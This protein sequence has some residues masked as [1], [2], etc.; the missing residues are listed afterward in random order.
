MP[1][2]KKGENN[3]NEVLKIIF[4]LMFELMSDTWENAFFDVFRKQIRFDWKGESYI[5]S[6]EKV[7][8]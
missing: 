5:L 3:M 7:D 4:E 1:V 6:L 8:E 2:L